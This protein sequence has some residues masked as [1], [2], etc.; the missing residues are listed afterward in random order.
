MLRITSQ[1]P[2][3][4]LLFTLTLEEEEL[5]EEE[6]LEGLGRRGRGRSGGRLG[7]REQETREHRGQGQEDGLQTY[8]S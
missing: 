2:N 8:Q 6:T 4:H 5:G 7:G 3:H 1:K